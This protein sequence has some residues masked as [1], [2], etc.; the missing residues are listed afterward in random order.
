MIA[1]AS[2]DGTDL[3]ASHRRAMIEVSKMPDYEHPRFWAGFS[4]V[5]ILPA[6]GQ[7]M[8]GG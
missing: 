4:L 6:A 2:S 7:Q 8:P 3:A 5:G 1:A